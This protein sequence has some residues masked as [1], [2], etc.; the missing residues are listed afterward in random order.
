MNRY[1]LPCLH[2]ARI[3]VPVFCLHL[4]QMGLLA[5]WTVQN[6]P[7]IDFCPNQ[8]DRKQMQPYTAND[9][10][11]LYREIGVRGFQIYMDCMYTRN[12]CNF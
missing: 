1:S 2:L 3:L 12:P 5:T 9:L 7:Y 10:Q 8:Q 11:G 6:A 4:D